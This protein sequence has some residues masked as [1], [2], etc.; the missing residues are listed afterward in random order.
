MTAARSTPS[1]LD[2]ATVDHTL[3]W[4]G[5]RNYLARPARVAAMGGGLFLLVAIDHFEAGPTAKALIAG[6]SFIGLMASPMTVWLAARFRLSISR[7]LA[8]FMFVA[9]AGIGLAA[10]SP[11]FGGFFF[12]TLIGAPAIMASAPLMT[13]LWNDSVPGERRGRRYARMTS[14]AGLTGVLSAA[15]IAAWLDADIARYR[16]VLLMLAGGMAGGALAALRI[17]SGRVRA[18][19]GNPYRRL[20]LIWRDRRFGLILLGWFL[21]GFGNLATMPLRLEHVAG[22]GAGFGYGPQ[23]VLWLTQVLPQAVGLLATLAW[24]RLFDRFDFLAIRIGLNLFFAASILAFFTDSLALQATG[25]ALLG[26]AQGGGTL[27]WGLWVT[28]YA[29]EDR[30]ADHM[31]AHTFLTGVRGLIGPLVAYHLAQTLRLEQIAWMGVGLIAI[32][33]LLFVFLWRDR[34]RSVAS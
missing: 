14:L 34:K 25:S 2:P 23:T 9:A 10:L 20:S 18:E 7:A 17:D 26:V 29:P 31:S 28:R 32:S 27:L 13:A 24:G 30:I 22:A 21:L 12:G 11:G 8:L 1:R 4:E 19:G 5:L 6:A 33:S 3:R 15:A 16:W